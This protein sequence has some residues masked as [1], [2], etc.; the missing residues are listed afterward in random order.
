MT[1]E[2]IFDDNVS[3]LYDNVANNYDTLSPS[4]DTYTYIL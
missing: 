4:F 3:Q 1:Y 2:N